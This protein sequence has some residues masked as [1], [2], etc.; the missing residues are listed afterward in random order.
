MEEGIDSCVG[1]LPQKMQL[2]TVSALSLEQ[3]MAPL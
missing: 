2:L 1:P 3:H